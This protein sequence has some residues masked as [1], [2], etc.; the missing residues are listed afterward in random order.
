MREQ[1]W[2]VFLIGRYA[3]R[4][5]CESRYIHQLYRD[6]AIREYRKCSSKEEAISMCYDYNK[7]LKGDKKHGN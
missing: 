6:R 4:I 2:H 3:Y 7:Y 5:R 1:N